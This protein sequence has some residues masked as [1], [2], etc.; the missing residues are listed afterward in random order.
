L[1]LDLDVVRPHPRGW[2]IINAD[3]D[4]RRRFN[5]IFPRTV[6]EHLAHARLGG[7]L[8]VTVPGDPEGFLAAVYGDWRT[9]RAKVHYLY[10]PNNVE[11]ELL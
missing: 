8:D 9:P 10:G 11:V 7:Q 5:Y 2:V 4:P 3:A 1:Y 6:F